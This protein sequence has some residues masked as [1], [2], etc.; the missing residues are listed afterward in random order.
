M[1]VEDKMNNED[2]LK[3]LSSVKAEARK[4][5]KV[6]IK[7]VFGSQA[8]GSS[9]GQSDVDILVRFDESSDLFDLVG[10]SL[11]LEEKLHCPVD[12]VP[13]DDIRSELKE[14]IL[15]ESIYI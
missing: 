10:L 2:I 15:K 4:R 3:I 9:T 5:Y 8:R 14:S 13:E 6:E 11:F 1:K 7:G 12:V